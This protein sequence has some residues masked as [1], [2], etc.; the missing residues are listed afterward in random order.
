MEQMKLLDLKANKQ[1]INIHNLHS[2]LVSKNR[3]LRLLEDKVFLA[4]KSNGNRKNMLE[5]REKS[6]GNDDNKEN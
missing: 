1:A 6:L 5:M 3:S 2:E 4:K